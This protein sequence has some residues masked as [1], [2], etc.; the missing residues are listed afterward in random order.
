MTRQGKGFGEGE[1]PTLSEEGIRPTAMVLQR[2]TQPSF[3]VVLMAE[4]GAQAA[5]HEAIQDEKR[6][7][8]ARA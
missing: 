4:Y 3:Q 7:N 8:R 2:M 1:K 5:P 6:P